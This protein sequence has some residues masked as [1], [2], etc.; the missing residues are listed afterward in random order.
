MIQVEHPNCVRILSVRMYSPSVASQDSNLHPFIVFI[1]FSKTAKSC[2][3][4]CVLNPTLP[5]WGTGGEAENNVAANSTETSSD[6]WY[7]LPS[8]L[9]TRFT[10]KSNETDTDGENYPGGVPSNGPSPECALNA[11]ITCNEEN[12]APTFE[13]FAGRSRR[14]SGLLSTDARPCG[15]VPRIVQNPCPVTQPLTE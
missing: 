1:S 12:S 11:C 5:Q 8:T 15:T 13:R 3:G 2:F 4:T 6:K 7:D 14:R 10:D 9:R